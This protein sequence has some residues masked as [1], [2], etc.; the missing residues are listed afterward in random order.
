LFV[1]GRRFFGATTGMIA[2]GLY[3]VDYLTVWYDTQARYYSLLTLLALALVYSTFR[4]VTEGSRRWYVLTGS[5]LT[6]L[7]YTHIITFAAAVC[8]VA[9][10]H[11]YHARRLRSVFRTKPLIMFLSV[12][13]VC[14]PWFIMV[15][16]WEMTHVLSDTTNVYVWFIGLFGFLVAAGILLLLMSPLYRLR[17]SWKFTPVACLLLYF[18]AAAIIKPILIPQESFAARTFVE[19]HTMY[20][21]LTGYLIAQTLIRPRKTRAVELLVPSM[22]LAL[23]IVAFTAI[24]EPVGYAARDA[25]WVTPSIA[26]LDRLHLTPETPV[27]VSYQQF[28][29]MLYTDYNVDPVWPLRKSYI[30]AYPGRMI[31]ILDDRMLKFYFFYPKSAF[32]KDGPNYGDRI[33]YCATTALTSTVTAYDCPPLQ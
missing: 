8:F 32:P 31:F 11:L 19:L 27:L 28:P 21:L 1:V 2:A 22:L 18:A 16:F 9:G 20:C 24:L 26:Y 13:A 6:L 17:P 25:S 4:A 12:A 23:V 3:A 5:I 30:D 29:F 10:A 14:T 7:F 33:V 15:R